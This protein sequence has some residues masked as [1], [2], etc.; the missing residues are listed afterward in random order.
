ML[1]DVLLCDPCGTGLMASRRD[2]K[3]EREDED[4]EKEV[5]EEV[6]R[7]PLFPV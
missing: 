2:E 1:I 7:R 6:S 3:R 4:P 5:E